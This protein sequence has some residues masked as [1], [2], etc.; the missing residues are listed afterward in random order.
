VTIK[1]KNKLK[2]NGNKGK[3]PEKKGNN[4]VKHCNNCNKNYHMEEQCHKKKN[5][6][7]QMK[8]KNKNSKNEKDKKAESNFMIK[9]LTDTL[10]EN[11][12]LEEEVSHE[13][14]ST[15]ATTTTSHPHYVDHTTLVDLL[16][17]VIVYIKNEEST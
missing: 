3:S 5:R 15:L 4:V 13:I 17:E 10:M 14:A 7:K 16:T 11:F 2:N 8:N 12:N 9:E 6:D 1:S